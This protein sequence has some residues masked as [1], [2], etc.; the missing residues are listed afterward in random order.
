MLP[1]LVPLRQQLIGFILFSAGTD[2]WLS[3]YSARQRQREGSHDHDR[4]TERCDRLCGN[5]L[6]RRYRIGRALETQSYEAF[7]S[8]AS[9]LPSGR[10]LLL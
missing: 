7:A 10:F 2:R 9:A 8:M 4:S 5:R 3:R 6:R 1:T